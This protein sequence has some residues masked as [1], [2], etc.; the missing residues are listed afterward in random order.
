MLKK[1]STTSTYRKYL[2]GEKEGSVGRIVGISIAAFVVLVFV[3][4]LVATI[5]GSIQ[6]KNGDAQTPTNTTTS[7]LGPET[8][9]RKTYKVA[10]V[11]DG[12]TIDIDMDGKTQR[13]RLIGVNTPETVHPEKAVECFGEEASKYTKSKLTGK[14]VEIETDD[15][16]D[17]YDK[18]N[19]LLAYVFLD[20]ENFN[21]AL[22]KN[23]YAYEY[24]YNVPYKYQKAFKEAQ[25]Y[26]EE[27]NVGLWAPNACREEKK[28][29]ADCKIKGNINSKG[30][31]IYH[32]PGQKYYDS[33]KINTSQGERWFCSEKEAQAA[34]WRKSKV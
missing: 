22:I 7:T 25:K 23:G 5:I 34:G 6:P 8:P 26:A 21:E 19:R 27:N 2:Q 3:I 12:D 11:V 28:T 17:K 14:E 29:T 13:I 20:G 15:S 4:F 9:V 33:T 24:T 18:Y 30:E 16:Q 10:N 32:M 31:K 1:Y